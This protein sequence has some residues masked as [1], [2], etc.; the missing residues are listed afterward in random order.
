MAT[1]SEVLRLEVKPFGVKVATV[2]TG[3]VQTNLFVNTPEY[4][5]PA[6]SRYKA[7]RKEI[8]SRATGVD[9]PRRSTTEEFA[10]DLVQD[11]L[12]G[13]TGKVYRGEMATSVRYA[14]ACIPTAILVRGLYLSGPIA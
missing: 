3:A 1:I 9:V 10:Q 14:T 12:R 13:A 4:Q 2:I 5:L 6:D 8:A 11:I 7:A